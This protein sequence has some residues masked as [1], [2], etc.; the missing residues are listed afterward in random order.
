LTIAEA[1]GRLVAVDAERG[2]ADRRREDQAQAQAE[3]D[4]RG[5]DGGGVAGAGTQRGEQDHRHHAEDHPDGDQRLGSG[6]GQ[7]RQAG[8]QRREAE[9]LLHEVG[10]EQ[11]RAEDTEP[12]STIDSACLPSP[13]S[14]GRS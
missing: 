5:Q 2:G 14:G 13:P 12:A 7:E 1:G 6:P 9:D 3:D 8:G 4:Q 10:E 11:E